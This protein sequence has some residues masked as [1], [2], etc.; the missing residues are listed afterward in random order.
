MALINLRTVAMRECR[1]SRLN[2][3]KK[4]IYTNRKIGAVDKAR[5]MLLN[6]CTHAGKFGVPSSRAHDHVFP[7]V[8]ACVNISQHAVR[9]GEI[10]DHINAIESF[11]VQT[12]S[13]GVV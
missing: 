2:Q 1:R 13:I 11:A 6:L 9:R 12:G 5:L 8:E 3:I 4:Q 10:Y 7:C